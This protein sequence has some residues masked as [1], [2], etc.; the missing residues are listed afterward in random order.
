MYKA[1][2]LSL[3]LIVSLFATD[4]FYY[5]GN[6]KISLIKTTFANSNLREVSNT[7]YYKTPDNLILGVNDEIILKIKDKNM[8][9]YLETKYGFTVI[10][11]LFSNTYLIKVTNKEETIQK[12]NDLYLEETIEYASPNFIKTINKR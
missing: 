10:K 6:K 3:S 4:D 2:F 1:I 8:L 11:E 7:T 9:K 5:N 12:A